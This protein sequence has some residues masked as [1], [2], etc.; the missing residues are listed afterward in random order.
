MDDVGWEKE[1][2]EAVKVYV[3]EML[4]LCGMCKVTRNDVIRNKY[5]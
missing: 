4:M 1:K 2:S 3:V 5:N